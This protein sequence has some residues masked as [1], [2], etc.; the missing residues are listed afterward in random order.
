[1]AKEI[2]GV[3]GKIPCI[4]PNWSMRGA[5][6]RAKW[7]KKVEP[8]MTRKE[9][10]ELM[11]KNFLKAYLLETEECL[12]VDEQGIVVFQASV[13]PYDR[14]IAINPALKEH[15]SYCVKEMGKVLK[16]PYAF[17]SRTYWLEKGKIT[18]LLTPETV[19]EDKD[20]EKVVDFLQTKYKWQN[21]NNKGL[22]N[23]VCGFH[24]RPCRVYEAEANLVLLNLTNGV[25]NIVPAEGVSLEVIEDPMKF[26]C[27]DIKFRREIRGYVKL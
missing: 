8:H 27:G 20:A 19:L 17:E 18:L 21:V 15:C 9:F 13:L 10:I 24:S 3:Y 1:M 22:Y 25:I 16:M 23:V 14:D 2:G 11:E 4:H 26:Y 6:S 12:R 7:A 5:S